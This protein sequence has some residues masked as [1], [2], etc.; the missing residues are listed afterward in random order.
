MKRSFLE[1]LKIE[2]KEV[3]DKILD[4]NSSDIGR[5]KGEVDGLN[6]Q[7]KNLKAEL[8]TAKSQVTE[9]DNQL[10]TLK[11]SSGDVDA[12]KKQIEEL[13]TANTESDK[14]FQEQIKNMRIESAVEQAILKAGGINSKAI[15]ALLDGSKFSINDEGV[16]GGISDQIE[17]LKKAEDSKMLFKDEKAS[18]KGAKVGEGNNGGDGFDPDK[19]TF[20]E[21][22]AYMNE[23]PDVKL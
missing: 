18:F 17:A 23:H 3:I 8:E 1:G 14:K 4:E 7:I 2:D 12:L 22:N 16:V 9:R 5:A 6:E 20:E 11:E 10:K 19:M 13:Q 21:L 15:K